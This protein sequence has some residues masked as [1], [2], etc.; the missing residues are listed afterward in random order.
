MNAESESLL[1]AHAAA[2]GSATVRP[3]WRSALPLLLLALG[4]ILALYERTAESIVLIWW[5]SDTFAHG[6]LIVPI[7]A[8]LIWQRRRELGAMSPR[9]DALGLILLLGA[10]AVWLVAAAGQVQVV[11]QYAMVAMIPA[12]VIAIAGRD[13]GRVLAFPLGFLFL[14]VPIGEFLIA[15]LMDWTAD[16]TILALRATGIPVFREGNFF[17][18]PSGSWSVVEGCSGLRYLIASI[19]IGVLFA[20]LTYTAL[21]KRLAFVA[22]SIAV[23]IIANWARAYM[24]VMI[25]HLS[26]MKL[27]HGVDHLIYGWVFFGLVMLLLFWVG[28]YWRD[29]PVERSG[30]NLPSG[31][32]SLSTEMRT[33]FAT[34]ALAGVVAAGAWPAYAAYLDRARDDDS[35][36]LLARPAAAAGWMVDDTPATGWLPHYDPASA[37]I[38]QTYRKG[39][40]VVLLY[41]A[42]YQHQRPGSQLVNSWNIMIMQKHPIWSNVA[43]HDGGRTSAPVRSISARRACVHGNS[44]C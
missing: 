24:I 4:A 26:D 12:T 3:E 10:G 36:G 21:W 28:S 39:D 8:W 37:R 17:T 13:V 44:A 25:G 42:Y 20:Y 23:P 16:V 9:P 35:L 7:S 41:L 34:F 32:A 14:A 22:C 27:A 33:R 38:I 40:R 18:I 30:S 6:F 31:R 29:T 1:R 19:T 11:Q 15:P 5:R 43:S 2:N